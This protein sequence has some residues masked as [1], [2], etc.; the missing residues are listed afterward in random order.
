MNNTSLKIFS[1]FLATIIV[2]VTIGLMCVVAGIPF[3][4]LWNWLIPPIFGLPKITLVQGFGLWMFL[5]L[6]RNTKFDFKET[7]ENIKSQQVN[8]EPIEWN[9]V[10]D[11][12]KKNYMA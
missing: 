3:Y 1:Y 5:L 12:V 4:L 9:Q 8:D 7:M 6:I 11:S 10:F 2:F